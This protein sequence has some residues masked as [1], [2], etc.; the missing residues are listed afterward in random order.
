MKKQKN[1]FGKL[2]AE[3]FEKKNMITKELLKAEIDNV[4]EEHLEK[5]YSIVKSYE[6]KGKHQQSDK[7]IQRAHVLREKSAIYVTDEEV[8]QMKNEGRP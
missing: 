2:T 6:P 3:N 7:F 5:I 4:P 8:T 1:K